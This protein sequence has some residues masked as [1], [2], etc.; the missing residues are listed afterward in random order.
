MR[1]PLAIRMHRLLWTP[2]RWEANRQVRRWRKAVQ[3]T[4]QTQEALLARLLADA[5]RT[6]FGRDAG[7]D[8]T[9]TVAD[10]RACLPI[11][12]YQRMA[13]Y[14]ERVARGDVGAL[15]PAGTR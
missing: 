10:L 11:A 5:A 12:G 6:D 3:Q 9:R 15:F 4:R 7:L 2:V 13:P 14:V 8:G 1:T